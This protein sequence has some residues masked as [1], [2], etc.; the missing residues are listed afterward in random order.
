M[1]ELQKRILNYSQNK[2]KKKSPTIG[3]ISNRA[4]GSA[5]VQYSLQRLLSSSHRANA[6]RHLIRPTND[7]QQ[8]DD[9]INTVPLISSI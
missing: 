5:G 6:A 1:K 7:A 9:N 4:A 8:F 2:V 3:A